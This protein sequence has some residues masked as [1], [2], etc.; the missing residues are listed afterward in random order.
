L[1]YLPFLESRG[2]TVRFVSAPNPE[3]DVRRMLRTSEGVSTLALLASMPAYLGHDVWNL[4][5][6]L[7]ELNPE[8]LHCWLDHPNI[9]GGIAGV[10]TRVTKVILSTRNYNPSHFPYLHNAWFHEWYQ[11]LALCPQVRYIANSKAGAKSYA[12]WMGTSESAINVVVNGLDTNSLTEATQRQVEDVRAELGIEEGVPVML[13]IFR[14]SPEKRPLEFVR[15]VNEIRRSVPN[16]RAF[17]AGIGAMATEVEQEIQK[18]GL[19][20][21]VTMLGRRD[22]VAP[23]YGVADVLLL[24]SEHEGTPNVLME[25]QWCRCPVV[26][27]NTGGAAEVVDNGQSGFVCECSDIK[28]LTE[29]CISILSNPLLR[30][31]MGERGRR[32]IIENFT[33]DRMAKGTLQVYG[34]AFELMTQPQNLNGGIPKLVANTSPKVVY[35]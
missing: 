12:D 10:L 19:V 29:Y 18:L 16:V 35:N 14:L 7:I 22:P 24:A 1:H 28:G 23:L 34:K 2:I 13:G 11:R 17:I 31:Q 32:F 30:T 27:T 20:D 26:C 6:H 5:T 25:A 9:I 3:F 33:V 15:I 8:V 4:Y 21:T